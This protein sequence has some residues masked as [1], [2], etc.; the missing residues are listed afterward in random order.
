M[1]FSLL[2]NVKMPTTVGILTFPSRKNFMLS[3]VAHE[4]FITSGHCLI[5]VIYAEPAFLVTIDGEKRQYQTNTES[6]AQA[7]KDEAIG[8]CIKI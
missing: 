4:I 1:L 8:G 3:W 7:T 2:K 5:C 6:I